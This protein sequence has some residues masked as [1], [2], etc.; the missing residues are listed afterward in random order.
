MGKLD[1]RQ[2]QSFT[3]VADLLNFTRAA[4]ALG[5]AQSSVTAQIRTLEE[6]VGYPLFDR[7][8]KRVILTEAGRRFRPYASQILAL[9]GEAQQATQEADHFRGTLRI[10]AAESLCVFRLPAVFRQYRARY[11]KVQIQL[12]AGGCQALRDDLRSG[13]LDVA[14]FLDDPREEADLVLRPL[15]QEPISLV[16][17]PWHP[18][19]S[20]EKVLPEHLVGQSLIHTE[21]ESTYRVQFDKII[22]RAGV[23]PVSVMEFNSIEAIKQCVMAGLGLA[24]LPYMTCAS[25]FEQGSL[26]ELPWAGPPIQSV[27]LMGYHKNKRI[28]PALAAFLEVVQQTLVK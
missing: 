7:L 12:Q 2:L 27:T 13:A 10:G 16:A 19:A 15:I 22:A 3:V 5:Y 17:Y 28:T 18:L 14:L 9:A 8:G 21:A 24:V 20:A 4:E 25:E 23:E 1:L 6:E 26:V 11:P